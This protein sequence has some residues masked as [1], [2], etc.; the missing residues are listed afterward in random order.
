M[1]FFQVV[2]A[3]PDTRFDIVGLGV[4]TVDELVALDHAPRANDKQANHHYHY[5]I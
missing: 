4:S 2:C 3:M 5:G 1:K